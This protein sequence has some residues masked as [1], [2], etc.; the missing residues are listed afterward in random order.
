MSGSQRRAKAPGEDRVL[1]AQLDG[2][3]AHTFPASDPVAIGRATATEPPAR[4]IER[5][6]PVFRLTR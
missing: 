6:A 1:D 5:R 2:A 4:P 3:L